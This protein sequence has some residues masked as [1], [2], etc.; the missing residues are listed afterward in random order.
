MLATSATTEPA[1]S[2]V[3]M[4]PAQRSEPTAPI[5]TEFCEIVVAGVILRIGPSVTGAAASRLARME[6]ALL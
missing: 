6:A 4:T 5:S 2:F 1:T 3:E